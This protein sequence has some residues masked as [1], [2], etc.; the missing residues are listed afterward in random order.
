MDSEA[1]FFREPF[2]LPAFGFELTEVISVPGGG[3]GVGDR[4]SFDGGKLIETGGEC[5]VVA[6][7]QFGG[8]E[9]LG[10]RVVEDGVS[11]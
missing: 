4:F 10:E 7:Y 6:G 2:E 3:V 9:V 5:A 1:G 11:Q 8:G